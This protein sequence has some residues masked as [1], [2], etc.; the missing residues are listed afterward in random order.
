MVFHRSVASFTTD[1]D[2]RHRSL[3][4]VGNGI[5][6]FAKPCIVARG[7]HAI[8][9]H[10]A[11][12]P[13][14]PFAGASVF[15]AID[16]K[17]ALFNRI[18]SGVHRLKTSALVGNE[19]LAERFVADDSANFVAGDFA[20]ES[21]RG[22]LTATIRKRWARLC[23]AVG[24]RA[25][26]MK[27]GIIQSRAWQTLGQTVVGDFPRIKSGRMAF[28]ATIRAGILRENS[29]FRCQDGS[30]RVWRRRF[31][32]RRPRFLDEKDS[33]TDG[34]KKTNSRQQLL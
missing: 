11:S 8:P 26:V 7:A 22:N 13:M 1:G 18:K 14:P 34:Q 27:S 10:A 32:L 4:R 17:P 25:S 15:V 21:E 30:G 9:V 31:L 2:F 29:F 3:I 23:A 33:A 5:V 19:K 16:A 28:P 20:L 12:R 6:V 24:K